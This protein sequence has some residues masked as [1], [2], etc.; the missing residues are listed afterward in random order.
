MALN[1]RRAGPLELSMVCR[2]CRLT[3]VFMYVFIINYL[4]ELYEVDR[5]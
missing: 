2:L 1:P 4:E 3:I 5:R